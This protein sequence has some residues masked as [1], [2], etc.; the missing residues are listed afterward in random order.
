MKNDNLRRLILAALFAAL[1]YV[2]TN[3]IHIPTPGTNGYLNLG[4]CTVLLGAFVLGPVYGAA[5]AGIGSMLADLLL[6]YVA[7]APGTL[8][9]KALMA[10]AAAALFRL[11]RGR[12][13]ALPAAI[14]AGV[15]GE[16]VMVFGYFGFEA[17]L[18]GYGPAAAASI[19][20]NLAQGALGIVGSVLLYEALARVP[21]IQK[22]IRANGKEAS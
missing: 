11:L 5:A 6:G 17:V 20:S 14:L 22:A 19:P 7:Y 2:T 16:L 13:H 4:D 9:I 3:I 10:F 12:L 18:L 21:A 8:V 15:A 1:T